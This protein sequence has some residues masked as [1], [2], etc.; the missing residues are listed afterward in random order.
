MESV[1]HEKRAQTISTVPTSPLAS[2][3]RRLPWRGAVVVLLGAAVSW[4]LFSDT[5]Q[6]HA[7]PA[8]QTSTIRFAHFGSFSDYQLWRGIIAEFTLNHPEVVVEQEYVVGLAGHY[9]TKLRQQVLSHTLPDLALIQFGPFVELVNHFADLSELVDA[10]DT[11]HRLARGSFDATAMASFVHDG[12]QQGLPVSGGNLLIYVNRKCIQRV[13]KVKGTPGPRPHAN[14]TM[15]EFQRI[16][17][18]LTSDLD[19]DGRIDQFGF[20]LPRW[21]YYLPFLWSFGAEL[22]DGPGAVWTLQGDAAEQA[23]R[24]YR[25]L[26]VGDRVCPRD[27]EVPQLFQDVGFLT[28]KVAMCVNGPWF[29]PFLDK[30]ALR[31]DYLVLPIPRGP[32]GRATR[33]TWDGVVMVDGLPP[34]R[35]AIAERFIRYL[36]SKR[37][38][39]RIAR[40]GR[41]L[42]ARIESLTAFIAS[43]Q[44]SRREPFVEAMA[45]SRLQ[46]VLP[47]FA[48]VDRAINRHFRYLIDPLSRLPPSVV[49]ERLA[50]DPAILAGFSST[51]EQRP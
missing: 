25:D 15:K 10:S 42:P 45:N 24:F 40:A 47:A 18:W 44:K 41:A 5:G 19:G 13:A 7:Q 22:T 27:E 49:L 26:A 11:G 39:D 48:R 36:L 31:D 34:K 16:A 3:D 32:G 9:E 23:L 12:R 4:W 6:R 51:K 14:W 50:N 38:Q 2:L 1:K 33:I 28:G 29:M 37:V 20:W 46:P 21:I 35:R 43:G 30:T 17:Q 8:D